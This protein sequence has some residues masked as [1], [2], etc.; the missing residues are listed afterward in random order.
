MISF[1]H[2][3]IGAKLTL[4]SAVGGALIVALMFNQWSGNQTISTAMTSLANEQALLD[5]IGNAEAAVAQMEI[6]VRNARLQASPDD[7]D[8]AVI[9]LDKQLAAIP[10]IPAS[11]A[12]SQNRCTTC[13]SDQP[14][15]SKC[16]CSGAILKKRLP[17]VILKYAT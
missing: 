14:S 3:S 13:V 2:L 5:S 1:A 15:N 16:K 10:N 6:A 17:L 7:V 9:E 8:N 11:N 12:A 4:T